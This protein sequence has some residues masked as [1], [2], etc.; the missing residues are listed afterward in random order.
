MCAILSEYII[1]MSTICK[2]V[3]SLLV[4]INEIH[5]HLKGQSHEKVGE[6]RP[7]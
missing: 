4:A 3:L 6:I 5:S 2:V 1:V 7:W